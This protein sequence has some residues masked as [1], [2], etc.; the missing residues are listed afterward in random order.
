MAPH[1]TIDLVKRMLKPDPIDRPNWQKI[2][3]YLIKEMRAEPYE[4]Y[5]MS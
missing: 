2:K 3:D 5:N 1:K 4:F